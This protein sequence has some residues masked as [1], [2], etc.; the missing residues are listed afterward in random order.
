MFLGALEG[1]GLERRPPL[2]SLINEWDQHKNE[3]RPSVH[4]THPCTPRRNMAKKIHIVTCCFSSGSN[5]E[6]KEVSEVSDIGSMG[7]PAIAPFKTTEP[8]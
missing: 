1:L 5:H 3:T 6:S 2:I 4:S 8:G 7:L